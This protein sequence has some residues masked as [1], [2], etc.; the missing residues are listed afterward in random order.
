MRQT[1]ISFLFFFALLL[2]E[3]TLPQDAQY[4]SV[5]FLPELSGAL[6]VFLGLGFGQ[7]AYATRGLFESNFRH[8]PQTPFQILPFSGVVLLLYV[9]CFLTNEH[10]WIPSLV[11]FA[12]FGFK[13]ASLYNRLPATPIVTGAASAGILIALCFSTIADL[14]TGIVS[15]FAIS[16]LAIMDSLIRSHQQTR[17]KSATQFLAVTASA[18][19]WH[20][21]DPAPLVPRV[22]RGRE[23][24][25]VKVSET[26]WASM[27][28]T[29]VFRHTERP[30]HVIVTNGKR[31]IELENTPLP[32]D[33]KRFLNLP[34][35]R[36]NALVIGPAGGRNVKRLLDLGYER[37]VAV[38]INPMVFHIIRNQFAEESSGVYNDPRVLTVT[39]DGRQFVK[40]TSERFDLIYINTVTTGSSPGIFYG[41]FESSIYTANSVEEMFQ[42]LNLGGAVVF[43]D[44]RGNIPIENSGNSFVSEIAK[45]Y[46]CSPILQHATI[47]SSFADQQESDWISPKIG[48]FHRHNHKLAL[49]KADTPSGES[50]T[51]EPSSLGHDCDR[52]ITDDKPYFTLTR[53]SKSL[54]MK[55]NAVALIA[56]VCL[57]TLFQRARKKNHSAASILSL[58]GMAYAL[59]LTAAGGSIMFQIGHPNGVVPFILF[60]SF[61]TGV[62]AFFLQNLLRQNM[63]SGSLL[64]ITLSAVSMY[65]L[66]AGA[67]GSITSDPV[68]IASLMGVLFLPFLL[69][70]L[71]FMMMLKSETARADVL[72]LE[73]LGSLLGIVIGIS[74]RGV[75]GFSTMLIA[76]IGVSIACV[77]WILISFNKSQEQNNQS[78]PVPEE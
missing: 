8:R 74:L 40:T 48:K 20:Y 12:G 59:G 11:I 33:T 63:V 46:A 42:K 18:L 71:P 27:F 60:L 7:V 29:E 75:V 54:L 1:L 69:L 53:W 35:G 26:H 30:L 64:L 72:T 38:D 62:V 45:S 67:I 57:I 28:R 16:L 44:T 55:I 51:S 14:S 41:Q 50:T 34:K 78:E 36:T 47:Q 61:I 73:N 65:I 58:S 25:V 22:F 56:F 23:S 4:A 77:T 21:F 24:A 19:A 2:L 15:S 39:Q 37:V 3:L 49:I 52:L 68:R 31:A 10:L 17:W 32:E 13:G 6:F 76:S 5:F 9:L 70:E 43:H 66:F